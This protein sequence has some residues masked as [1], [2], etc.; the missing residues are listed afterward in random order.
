VGGV[1]ATVNASEG[2]AEVDMRSVPVKRF[3]YS[4]KKPCVMKRNWHTKDWLTD[5]AIV[6]L[7]EYLDL[8]GDDPAIEVI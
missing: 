1:C 7:D 3:I 6:E 8:G 2:C 4:N 5:F